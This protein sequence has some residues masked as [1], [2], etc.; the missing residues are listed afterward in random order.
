MKQRHHTIDVAKFIA[1]FFVVG[2]HTSIFYDNSNTVNFIIAEIFCRLAVP[3]FAVCSGYFLSHSLEKSYFSFSPIK[4]QGI[5]LLRLYLLW[6]FLYFLFTIPYAIS[7]GYFTIANYKGFLVES[8]FSGSYYHLWY[9]LS[10]IYALPVFWLIIKIIKN[11]VAIFVLSTALYSIKVLTYSY[12]FILPSELTPFLDFMEQIRAIRNAIFLIL[13]LMLIGYLI[14]SKKSSNKINNTIG[15]VIST[16]F[17][18]LEAFSLHAMNYDRVSFIIFTYPTAYFLFSVLLSIELPLNKQVCSLLG[19]TSLIIYC[20]HPMVIELFN[21]IVSNSIL[22]FII[23]A[24]VSVL[25]SL[26]VV[27][28]KTRIYK[29]VNDK[30]KNT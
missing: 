23:V 16:A 12:S 21:D 8:I 17:L 29:N 13:P 11:K 28:I 19:A 18:F 3:F 24:T 25:V 2:I 4:R 30:T 14:H 22:M 15:L 10:V 9:L 5:K 20:F 6:T 7:G 26:T 1:S 27:L